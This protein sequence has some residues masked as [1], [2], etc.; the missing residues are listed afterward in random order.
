MIADDDRIGTIS[1]ALRRCQIGGLA[2]DQ[3]NRGCVPANM[4][5]PNIRHLNSQE[6]YLAHRAEYCIHVSNI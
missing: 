4:E 5:P 2:D 6:D 1:L 3:T